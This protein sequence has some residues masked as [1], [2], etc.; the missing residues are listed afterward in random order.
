MR[1]AIPLL[2]WCASVT[3][4]WAQPMPAGPEFRVNSDT[5]GAQG[6]GSVAVTADGGFVVVWQ[7]PGD[8]SS[9]GVFS[10]RYDSAGAR[11]GAEFQVNT[12]TTGKQY[13]AFRRGVAA[14]AAG[15]F[16][17][18]WQSEGQDGDG[19]GVFG[20]RFDSSGGSAGAEFLVNTYTT[21]NQRWPAVAGGP[22]GGFVVVW[23]SDDQD[24]D[25]RGVFGQRFD[26]GGGRLD[27][28]F[29][30][31]TYT[32]GLQDYPAVAALPD[33]GFLV[34]WHGYGA[35]D[36][37]G[38]GISAQ[39]FGS[40]GAPAG[41]EFQVNSYTTSDQEFPSIATGPG[42]GFVVVWDSGGGS[43]ENVLGRRFDSSGATTGPEFQVNTYTT[44]RQTYPM[45]AADIDGDFVVVWDGED[46][47]DDG[48]FGQRFDR[49]ATRLGGEFPVNTYTTGAQRYADITANAAGDLVVVWQS[50]FGQDGDAAGIFGQRIGDP[51][52]NGVL[53]AGEECDDGNRLAGDC[54]G[55]TC[56]FEP[57]GTACDDADQCTTLAQCEAGECRGRETVPADV[58]CR[59]TEIGAAPCGGEI[60]PKKLQRRVDKNVK[61][62]VRF[63]GK[64]E[65]A[66]STRKRNA[67]KKV[68]RFRKRA[69]KQVAAI[70]RQ[71]ARAARSRKQ[72]RRISESCQA[73]IDALVGAVRQLIDDFAF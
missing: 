37:S 63:V 15:G 49:V 56:R 43:N 54:C 71:A 62:A 53:D 29:E 55:A 72:N 32:T 10:R 51:C 25:G 7:S 27:A 64:A 57:S 9:Y 16:V 42:G 66:A 6:Y 22:A 3:M 2:A 58:V 13:A 26:S 46:A 12:Y 38:N 73:Q 67:D 68:K 5:T 69:A 47:N 28:E 17:V 19:F 41:A 65:R 34:A 33:R 39:R 4:A 11:A 70:S 60:L 8:G 52:G 59:L 30:V 48:V 44:G 40:T 21:S 20:Q 61:R 14:M 36:S 23:R 1:L 31:N 35:G 18:V 24:G 50:E 45:V